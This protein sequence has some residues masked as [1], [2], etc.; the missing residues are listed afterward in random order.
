[1]FSAI[2]A[3]HPDVEVEFIDENAMAEMPIDL[4]STIN[5]RKKGK[6]KKLTNGS[7]DFAVYIV[8]GTNTAMQDAMIRWGTNLIIMGTWNKDGTRGGT[9]RKKNLD[10]TDPENPIAL[11]DIIEGEP[12]VP[13][14]AELMNVLP[15]K[16]IRDKDGVEI[17]RT[18]AVDL[19]GLPVILGHG[20]RTL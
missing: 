13:I 2:V 6:L 4:Q 19:S 9:K 8:W 15:D 14:H 1:M 3:V 16:V 20:V 18:P 12:T 10:M 7:T 17:S 5:G 11:A